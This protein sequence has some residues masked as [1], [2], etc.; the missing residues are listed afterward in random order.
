MKKRTIVI[1]AIIAVFTAS[2]VGVIQ[3]QLPKVEAFA[4]F[5]VR[6]LSKNEKIPVKIDP[7]SI[8]VNLLPPSLQLNNTAITPKQ[9]LAKTIDPLKVGKIVIHPSILDLFIGHFWIDK[10]EVEGTEINAKIE[11]DNKTGDGELT[12][13][14]SKTLSSI[15]VSEI[16][17]KRIKLRIEIKD[18]LIIGTENFYLRAYNQ[19]NSLLAKI[20]EPKLSVKKIGREKA[21]DVHVDGQFMITQSTLTVSK[22][23]IIKDKSFVIGSGS[24]QHDGKF[25]SLKE[26]RFSTRVAGNFV[27]IDEWIN[28]FQDSDDLKLFKG[29][30]KADIDIDKKPKEKLS[31]KIKTDLDSFQIGKV[32]LGDLELKAETP[33]GKTI[34]IPRI[35]IDLAG[36]GNQVSIG[37]AQ[38]TIG[39]D[40]KIGIDAD[41]EIKKLEIKSFL[42]DSGITD[43]PVWTR[44]AGKLKC[45]GGYDKQFKLTCPGNLR[46][47]NV[48]VQTVKSKRTIVALKHG[49]IEGSV[50][51]TDKA[52]SYDAALK[53][54]RSSGTSK[55]VIDFKKGFDISY[56]TDKIHFDEVGKIAELEFAGS[57]A[58]RGSTKGDSRSAVFNMDVAA[59]N[60]EFQS[61]Y[62]GT[63]STNLNYKSGTLFFENLDGNLESTRFKGRLEVDLLAERITG[64]LTLPFFRMKDVQQAVFKKVDLQNRFLG[65]GSG[66]IKIATSFD[67]DKLSFDLKARLFKGL[68]FGETYD[69]AQI[70]VR[71][72]EGKMKIIRGILGKESTQFNLT[73]NLN[74]A[75][76]SDFK[77]SV[78]NGDLNDSFL[79]RKNSIPLA[80]LFSAQGKIT[81]K[82]SSPAIEVE[83]DISQFTFNRNVYG[84]AKFSYADK[85]NQSRITFLLDKRFD[86]KITIPKQEN[87]DYFFNLE[88]EDFDVAPIIGYAI[89]EG[90]TQNYTINTSGELSGHI[91]PNNLWGS[92]FSSLIKKITISYKGSELKSQ[93]PMN[94]ELKNNKLYLNELKL[95]GKNQYLTVN[96]SYSGNFESRFLID[97]RIN[98]SF[99]KLFAPFIERIDGFSTVRLELDLKKNNVKLFGSSYTIDAY[100]QFPKFP[101]PFE[102]L[103]ADIL[104]NQNKVSINSITGK[105]AGGKVLGNGEFLVLGPKDYKLDI[106]MSL[107]KINLNFPEGIE[108]TGDAQM[109]FSGSKI[110]F[111]LKG[112]Y[113]VAKGFIDMEFKGSED[114]NKNSNLLPQLLKKSEASPIMLD[115]DID[116]RDGVEVK[117]T[118]VEG[119]VFGEI[120]VFDKV[121]APK[122]TGNVKLGRTSRLKFRDTEFEVTGS[123]FNFRG[124]SPLNPSLYL[125][126]KTRVQSYD[127]NM[128]LQG[129]SSDP[130]LNLSSQPPLTYRKIISLLAFGY[131]SDELEDDIENQQNNNQQ[132]GLQIGT[133]LLGNNPLGREIKDRLGWD[134]QF[135]S[136]IDDETSLAVPKIT[137]SKKFFKK[138]EASANRQE[139]QQAQTE[140]RLRYELD[141]QLSTVLRF[142]KKEFTEVEDD[143]TSLPET[144]NEVGVD[145]EYKFEFK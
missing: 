68:A 126:A 128:L 120:R 106:N 75:L 49:D 117:N 104:F 105:M 39:E 14:F 16:L 124:L 27:K 69:Q 19:K 134:I 44:T 123:N 2:A 94:I 114:E 5:Y 144:P 20:K 122:I 23:K 12:F 88:T 43:I 101:H 4:A 112:K 53:T 1:L 138:V 119:D 22:I 109:R 93:L 29:S 52:V 78:I 55:G 102:S 46:V 59:E 58:I 70:E 56:Q 63:L 91:N 143:N 34:S 18:D 125:T 140:V 136:A 84:D 121:D 57:A 45:S 130:K 25:K 131:V 115:I 65:S 64:D 60:F 40:E 51:V 54:E 116:A 37:K 41:L 38:V 129:T 9:E 31:A 8:E 86:G 66:Q 15:P 7:Q 32:K 33:D 71:S 13:D 74:M 141:E 61:Y 21:L 99:F 48:K 77:F 26:A 30:F 28:T 95:T 110:P 118:L 73:G 111:D 108:T 6:S 100:I 11:S 72:R 103:N 132:Q 107:E 3:W 10:I 42:R 47:D 79:L 97:G 92:E 62:F 90:S 142:R 98:I 85:E 83:A 76:D 133:S 135:S 35:D 36:D 67:T 137:V 81:G 113:K 24:L 80:G 50:T 89:A 87:K 127:V 139:G 96:Q 17:L 82:L 145:L